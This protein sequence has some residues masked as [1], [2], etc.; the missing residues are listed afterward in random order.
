LSAVGV[1]GLQNDFQVF[2]EVFISDWIY[3]FS[4]WPES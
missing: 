1:I 2:I 3:D 4:Q